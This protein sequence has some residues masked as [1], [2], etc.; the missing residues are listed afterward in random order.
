MCSSHWA[1]GQSGGGQ[2][3]DAEPPTPVMAPDAFMCISLEMSLSMSH[4][5][6][7]AMFM[8]LFGLKNKVTRT[9]S[10]KKAY[11]FGIKMSY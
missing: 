3:Q 1:R 7:G 5:R 11:L 9:Q 10:K 8:I 6:V 4:K 2:V